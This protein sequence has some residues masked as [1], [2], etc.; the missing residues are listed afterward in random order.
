MHPALAA[1]AALAA[2]AL[3]LLRPALHLVKR[4]VPAGAV[5]KLQRVAVWVADEDDLIPHVAYHASDKWLLARGRNPDKAGA[6]E[7]GSA[8]NY[9]RW[10][11]LQPSIVLRQL[12]CAYHDRVVGG[13]NADGRAAWRRAVEGGTYDSVLRFDGEHVRHPALISPETFFAEMT[14]SY[15]GFNDHYPF[16][17]F[18]LTQHDPNTAGLLKDLWGGKAK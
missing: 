7:I 3:R 1:K 16:I 17:Q 18:E 15:Y 10:A 5:A 13:D 14:E 11:G 9:V 4:A 6:V 12:A 2:A 8:A